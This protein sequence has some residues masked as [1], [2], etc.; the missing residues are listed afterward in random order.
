MPVHDSA[1]SFGGMVGVV[2]ASWLEATFAA[3]FVLAASAADALV[4]VMMMLCFLMFY[5]FALR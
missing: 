4:L 2:V 1:A 3:S 5:E